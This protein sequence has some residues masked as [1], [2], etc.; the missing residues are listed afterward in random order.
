M[1]DG[2]EFHA[3]GSEGEKAR[4]LNFVCNLGITYLSDGRS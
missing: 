1:S 2:S 4:C 3:V